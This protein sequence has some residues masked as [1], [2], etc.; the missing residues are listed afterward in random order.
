MYD[1]LQIYKLV[2]WQVHK[3]ASIQVLKHA[4]WK[5]Y[6]QLSKNKGMYDVCMQLCKMQVHR[7]THIEASTLQILMYK[8]IKV[9]KCAGAY[10]SVQVCL[11]ACMQ[12]YK[13]ARI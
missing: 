5:V 11:Y 3:Y 13:Y 1:N 12:V 8:R 10:L 6:K 2:T 7:F 4:S 9:Y